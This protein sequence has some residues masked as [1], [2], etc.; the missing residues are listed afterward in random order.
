MLGHRVGE[1]RIGNGGDRYVR[2]IWL[3]TATEPSA[4]PPV[5]GEEFV[6]DRRRLIDRQV[7]DGDKTGRD[8]SGAGPSRGLRQP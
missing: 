8:G 4:V 6:Q 2:D 5:V 3:S 7:T 1:P